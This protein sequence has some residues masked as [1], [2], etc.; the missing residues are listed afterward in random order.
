MNI[1]RAR[2]KE[3]GEFELHLVNVGHAFVVFELLNKQVWAF[4]SNQGSKP[5]LTTS[6]NIWAIEHAL[7]RENASIRDARF[8]D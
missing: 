2:R 7:R 6:H 5:L 4:D 3:N 1:L 8:L